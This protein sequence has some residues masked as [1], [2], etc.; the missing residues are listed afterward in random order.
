MKLLEYEA[1]QL[2]KAF[3]IPVPRGT[4]IRR[5]WSEELS[6]PIVLKSQVPVGGRGKAGGVV[7]VSSR[8]I[9]ESQKEKLFQLPIKDLLPKML[10]AEEVIDIHKEHYLSLLVDRS[11]SSIRLV[12]HKNGGVDVE[13]NNDE[14]FFNEEVTND[15]VKNVSTAVADFL[16]HDTNQ[17]AQF[18]TKLYE[19]FINNDVTLLE[20]NPLIVTKEGELV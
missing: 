8:D 20:I 10:L 13:N 2:L 16:E 3:D 4:I 19:I 18:I 15:T 11:T 14:L 5:N 7:I 9:Y 12:A 17:L 6:F 1:K